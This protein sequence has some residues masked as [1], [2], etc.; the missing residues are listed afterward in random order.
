MVKYLVLPC[1][2]M[3]ELLRD[4]NDKKIKSGEG[5]NETRNDGFSPCFQNYGA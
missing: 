5:I 2:I 3:L 1:I 4:F